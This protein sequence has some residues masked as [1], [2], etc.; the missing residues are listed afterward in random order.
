[1]NKFQSLVIKP[2]IMFDIVHFIILTFAKI[3]YIPLHLSSTLLQLK[4]F[5]KQPSAF[6]MTGYQ[7]Q[8][9]LLHDRH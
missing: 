7:Q 9:V 8:Q 5:H 6:R 4:E 2:K 1:M 3:F